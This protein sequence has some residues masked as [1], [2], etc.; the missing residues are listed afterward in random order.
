M[1]HSN[2]EARNY[3]D[4][5]IDLRTIFNSLLARKFLIIGITGFFTIIANLYA[6]TITQTYITSSSFVT[7][8]E[9]SIVAI[10]KI[11][12]AVETK[13]SVL[14]KFL[15]QILSPELQLKVFVDGNYLTDLNSENEQ[16]DDIN[17]YASSFFSSFSLESPVT[18]DGLIEKPYLASLKGSN[19]EITSRYLNELIA[20]ANIKT[21]DD[22]A[23][24][25]KLNISSRLEKIL[26]ERRLL[27]EQAE[28]KRFSEI[29]RM[30]E[31]DAQKIREIDDQIASLK[32]QATHYRLTQIKRMK[33]EDA[34]K[35]RE[36]NDQIARSRY[37]AKVSRLNQIKVLT[38]EAQ[39]AGFLG[40]EDN[41]LEKIN[42][43]AFSNDDSNL[44][45][46]YL[47]GEKALLQRIKILE[48]R[49]SDD[50]FIE[51]LVTLKNQLNEI[52]LN[53]TLKTIEARQDDDP[54]IPDI[55]SLQNTLKEVQ[56]NNTLKTLEARQDDSPFIDDI[57]ELDI[58][59]IKL[60]SIVIDMGGVSS[61]QIRQNT[62]SRALKSNKRMIVLLAFIGSFM[63]S[64]FLALIMGALKSDKKISA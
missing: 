23:T 12:L 8:P 44:P 20:S 48:N 45:D 19:T 17:A 39:L 55:L 60:E 47:Y 18:V 64:I 49:K 61:I 28:K 26:I 37:K 7:A 42:R 11:N 59:K 14:A 63:M 22:L 53:N 40:V 31:E 50:P 41:N 25:I 33:E 6:L 2:H 13:E 9:S 5:E 24:S 58:E 46:W 38:D 57:I 43:I 27:I 4:D 56:L 36:I 10:N 1:Q 29:E 54:F 35:I 15:A 3:Q 16:I 30:K 32:M 52:E 51:E 34:Q 21:I 62:T